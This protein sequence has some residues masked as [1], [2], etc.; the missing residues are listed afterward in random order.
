MKLP[1]NKILID[2]K[3]MYKLN[4]NQIGDMKIFKPV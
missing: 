1:S 2:C 4:D 3:C